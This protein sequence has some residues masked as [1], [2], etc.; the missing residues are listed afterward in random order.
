MYAK[1]R[2]GGNRFLKA[3]ARTA[4]T[5]TRVP[6]GGLSFRWVALCQDQGGQAP[7]PNRAT[8]LGPNSLDP[9]YAPLFP[10]FFHYPISPQES[11]PFTSRSS[12][13]IALGGLDSASRRAPSKCLASLGSGIHGENLT[14]SGVFS[15]RFAVF[16]PTSKPHHKRFL[17]APYHGLPI[18]PLA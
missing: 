7:V 5:T 11:L 13:P 8:K 17:V 14:L 2:M 16:T 10:F 6:A 15:S 18:Q 3:F 1:Q 4:K 9:R 12:F